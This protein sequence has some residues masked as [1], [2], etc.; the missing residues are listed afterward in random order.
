MIKIAP[1]VLAAD[2][3]KLESQIKEVEAAG[4]D[5]IHIDVMDGQYVPNITFGPVIVRA[6][7]RIT[8]LPLDV[9]LM[10]LEPDH[11]IPSFIDAGASNITVHIEAIKHIHR[12]IGLIKASGLNAGITLNPGTSACLLD[13]LIPEIDLILLMTVNPGFGGQTFI[14]NTLEKIRSIRKMADACGKDIYIEVDGGIDTETAPLTVKAGANVLVAG[15]SIF[16]QPNIT[17]ALQKLKK[18]VL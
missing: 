8:A 5:W 13:S 18:S 4:A 11:L 17:D 12:T 14:Y 15:T 3:T 6:I 2:F 16:G 9:H 1:S 10:V 7:R